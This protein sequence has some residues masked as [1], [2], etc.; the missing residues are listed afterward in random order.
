MALPGFERKLFSSFQAANFSRIRIR[1]LGEVQV[2]ENRSGGDC[3][4]VRPRGDAGTSAEAM[5]T[6]TCTR[7]L[8]CR[9]CCID[10]GKKHRDSKL[11]SGKR[12]AG[13]SLSSGSFKLYPGQFLHLNKNFEIYE[14]R[15]GLGKNSKLSSGRTGFD[16]KQGPGRYKN[17]FQNF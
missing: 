12:R 6:C 17:S 5:C 8:V 1:D 7:R 4:R 9:G 2:V 11:S 3:R 13:S 14:S 15:V 16:S 10:L